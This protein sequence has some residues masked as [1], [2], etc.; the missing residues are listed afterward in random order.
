LTERGEGNDPLGLYRTRFDE[1]AGAELLARLQDV[2]LGIN[3]VDDQ[4][5]KTDRMS[6]AH[7]LEVRVPFLD[8]VVADLA[9]STASR[10]KV[11]GLR[12]KR[13]L[14][15]AFRPLVPEEILHGRKRGFSMPLSAW[16]R[17][18]LAGFARETLAPERL[19]AHGLL[20]PAPVMRLLDEHVTR[21]ADRSRQLWSLLVLTLWM[22]SR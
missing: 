13:L 10:H 21:R 14:R 1:T 9:F 15:E 5:V 4:L 3:L 22:D 8:P 6:M 2:D 12:K 16:L 7:S 19:R 17:G 20:E 18:E 11:Q